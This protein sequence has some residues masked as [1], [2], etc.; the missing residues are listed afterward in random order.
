[1]IRYTCRDERD[2]S[3][4]VSSRSTHACR[5]S[6]IVTRTSLLI[7]NSPDSFTLGNHIIRTNQHCCPVVQK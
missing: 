5:I 3:T 7:D 2:G 4:H 1:M 6:I